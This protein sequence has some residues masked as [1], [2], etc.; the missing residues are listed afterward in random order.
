M[1]KNTRD[2]ISGL[3][4]NFMVFYGFISTSL[5]TAFYSLQSNFM[6]FYG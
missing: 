4:S 3:Q 6:V 2:N 1:L 5:E